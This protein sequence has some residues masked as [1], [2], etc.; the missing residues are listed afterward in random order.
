MRE[1][2]ASA[3][4]C[5]IE[6]A[7][8]DASRARVKQMFDS[9]VASQGPAEAKAA[10]VTASHLAYI[11]STAQYDALKYGTRIITHSR[12]REKD[13]NLVINRECEPLRQLTPCFDYEQ[14]NQPL[15][16]RIRS[17]DLRS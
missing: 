4:H 1:L 3:R 13:H 14:H 5:G 9:I 15:H 7:K 8:Q 16:G 11:E 12:L 2:R 10:A 17:L 6:A